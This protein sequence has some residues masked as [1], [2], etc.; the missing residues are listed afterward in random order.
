MVD[1]E[2][3][4]EL[5]YGRRGQPYSTA[6]RSFATTLLYYSPKAYRF[7]RNR[8]KNNLPHENTVVRWYRRIGGSPGITDEALVVLETKAEERLAEGKQLFV[9]LCMDEMAIRQH[10]Q[11]NTS[12]RKIDGGIDYGGMLPDK[13]T[14]DEV[15][16][17]T[18]A[19]VFVVMGVDENFKI[20]VAYFFTNGLNAADKNIIVSNVLNALEQAKVKVIGL[21]FDGTKANIATVERF[22]C[23]LR[24]DNQPLVT[25]FKH[26]SGGHNVYVI[27][28]GCHM[29]KLVRN[30][31]AAQK[32]LQTI[33]GLVEWTFIEK[34]NTLQ[35]LKNAKIAPKLTNKH[36]Y[37]TNQ[38]MKVS[39]AVQTLSKSVADALE[40]LH[41][42]DTDFVD[43][44]P[45][46]EFIT[47][48]N[49]L[50]DFM[51]S[52]EISLECFKQ[53]LSEN[54]F[55]AFEGLLQYFEKYIRNIKI[56]VL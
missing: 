34:L 6:L 5:I 24:I 11:F 27:L 54:N 42:N 9:A 26:P 43:V 12:T 50:F 40:L 35:N 10:V 39:L 46:V 51:N 44:L 28:D 41:A 38:K 45:T 56:N 23:H 47:V 18:E 16:P 48:F 19:L 4:K 25:H 55:S 29:V 49:N 31:F 14:D 15:A 33:H 2:L 21:T 7:V 8:F 32:S 3:Q 30:H 52:S 22:G 20:P 17:A 1:T 36:V 53:P 37:F 13:E